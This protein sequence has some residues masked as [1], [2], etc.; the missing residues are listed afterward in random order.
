MVNISPQLCK[1]PRCF[2]AIFYLLLLKNVRLFA[3]ASQF[4]D[5]ERFY[6]FFSLF[7]YIVLFLFTFRFVEPFFCHPQAHQLAGVPVDTYGNTKRFLFCV[8]ARTSKNPIVDVPVG[9]PQPMLSSRPS[10]ISPNTYTTEP[11]AETLRCLLFWFQTALSFMLLQLP[12]LQPRNSIQVEAQAKI[13]TILTSCF[14]SMKSSSF[15]FSTKSL[16]S[17]ESCKMN[18]FFL[19]W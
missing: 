9:L 1:K 15:S 4:W 12:A 14:T 19:T 16:F 13:F 10:A 3:I 18:A 11:S 8:G 7:F 17:Y 6:W 5:S 2:P